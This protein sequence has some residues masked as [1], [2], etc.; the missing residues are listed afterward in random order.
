[1]NLTTKGLLSIFAI[2][3]ITSC[4]DSMDD[5]DVQQTV[6]FNQF[7]PCTA[8]PDYSEDN[9]RKFVADWNVLVAEYDQMVWAGGLAP[10]S[11]QQNGWWELQW[12][13][14]E[15]SE[16]AWQANRIIF[17]FGS[18]TFFKNKL[19]FLFEKELALL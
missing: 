14:Q 15:A 1:M 16:K 18:S 9:M 17:F 11:G 8:G 5:G 7:I 10:A 4:S 2:I 13:S 19:E 12:T 3:F 6:F